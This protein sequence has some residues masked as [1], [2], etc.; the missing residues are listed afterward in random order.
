MPCPSTSPL[1]QLLAPVIAHVRDRDPGG[2]IGLYLYGSA[3]SLLRP[4]SDVDLLLLTRRS[5]TAEERA[6][7][8]ALLLVHS[9]WRGH[10]D[11]F[12]DA[13]ERR[14]LELTSLVLDDVRP[15]PEH[16]LR[17]FQFG[18][19]RRAELLD[20]TLPP[21]ER[22]PDIVT[23]LATA[24]HEHRALLGPPL[25]DLLDTVSPDLLH[26]TVIAS[27]PALIED[28]EGDERHVLL[29]L[30]RIVV[31]ARTGRIVAKDV[32]ADHVAFD[33]MKAERELLEQA[34]DGYRGISEDDWSGLTGRTAAL[35]RH[36]ADLA[37]TR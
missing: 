31:T 1:R 25:G 30:A 37:R 4:D 10:A 24:Q 3:V 35:A 9:G 15:L 21:P 5:L 26:R 6:E 27:I 7:L 28:L 32:A 33:L 19:W 20:G 36:L 18:E 22:D 29:T 12:P 23:L 16:P 34:R 14:P 11:R 13:A 8:I 17:D 2:I